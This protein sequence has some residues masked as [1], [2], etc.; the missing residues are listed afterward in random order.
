M[1][2]RL[3]LL[4]IIFLTSIVPIIVLSEYGVM[5][6]RES[7]ERRY[8][9]RLETISF[10]Q[11]K[12]IE[13]VIENDISEVM[14]IASRTNLRLQ[15]KNYAE[16]GSSTAKETIKSILEDAKKSDNNFAEITVIGAD[17]KVIESTDAELTE[18]DYFSSDFFLNGKSEI[19]YVG[20]E[21]HNDGIAPYALLT[22]PLMQ[23]GENIGLLRVLMSQKEILDITS[24]Y[25]GLGDT[26]ETILVQKIGDEAAYLTP[27]RHD[28]KA[29]SF[30]LIENE[31]DDPAL[32]SALN[33]E[34]QV[35]S[36]SLDYRGKEVLA[37][38]R[39]IL[40]VNWGLVVK[41][42]KEEAI[43]EATHLQDILL[44]VLLIITIIVF[45]VS[46]YLLQQIT[47][48]VIKL[49]YV[50]NKISKGNLKTDIPSELLKSQDEIGDLARAFDRTMVSLKLA[51]KDT[52]M[53][54]NDSAN[55]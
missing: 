13:S 16:T 39:N 10:L 46:L 12:R 26:G 4:L 40:P 8:L 20:L 52:I 36:D 49:T 21:K 18:T 43:S 50:I 22:S 7:L 5:A 53:Q 24:E 54:Q 28:P 41:M 42:D 6:F 14:L 27:V 3:K 33:G 29:G 44:I 1:T 37:S 38:T 15:V 19:K 11:T 2:F 23:E 31:K 17:G 47:D 45:L 55:K 48:P 9:D 30:K 35:S 34:E 32:L 51:M 25:E